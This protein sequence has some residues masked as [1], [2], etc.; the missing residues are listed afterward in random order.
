MVPLAVAAGGD[1]GAPGSCWCLSSQGVALRIWL[2]GRPFGDEIPHH[3]K[4]HSVVAKTTHYS[5]YLPHDRISQGGTVF[6]FRLAKSSGFARPSKE[7]GRASS[8]LKSHDVVSVAG[9]AL[10]S[11]EQPSVLYQRTPLL[12]SSPLG[13][14]SRAP[15]RSESVRATNVRAAPKRAVQRQ[16]A[17]L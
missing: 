3:A 12:A 17:G 6:F 15:P 7:A 13:T 1:A 2:L 14:N 9:P 16:I 5:V 4:V 10:L 8:I 11:T